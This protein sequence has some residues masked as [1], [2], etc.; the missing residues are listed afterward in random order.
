[1]RDAQ[2]KLKLLSDNDLL[3]K[4]SMLCDK[5]LALTDDHTVFGRDAFKMFMYAVTLLNKRGITHDYKHKGVS[6]Y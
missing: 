4:T 5:M 6:H 1:M 2:A 3:L